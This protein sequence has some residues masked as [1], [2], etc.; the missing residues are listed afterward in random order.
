MND[1]AFVVAAKTALGFALLAFCA[2]VAHA[3]AYPAKPVRLIVPFSP[4]GG[5]DL[6]G[7][8][9]AQGLGPLLGQQV[10][11]E[12][13]PGAGGRIGTELLARAA[14]DGYTLLL[15]GSSAL[16][17][18]P[19]LYAKLPYRVPQDFAP[20][21]L[22]GRATYVLVVHPSV[23]AR[24]VKQ[25]VT[26]AKAQP[27]QLTYASSGTGSLGHLSGEFFSS[28]VSVKLIHVPYKGSAP[29]V[30]SVMTGETA[31]MFSNVVPA[32]PHLMNHRLRPLGVTGL[33]R[34]PLLPEVP[35]VDESGLRGF[36]VQQLYGFL[37]PAGT[38]GEIV[39]RLNQEAAR[40]M[41]APD[42]K[43]RLAAD[44]SEVAVSSPEEF[45]KI[46]LG[47]VAKWR[48][49]IRQAGITPE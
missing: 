39:R 27:G 40:V 18:A 16:V 44:G 14:P 33:A 47:E 6:L 49:V 22:I 19:A 32:L 30:L 35:T 10:I 20:I 36:E 2:P 12:N 5:T 11:V 23:P 38:P 1:S 13:R 15:V 45:E 8:S 41:Q 31:I 21:T 9:L 25:L 42:M 24:T 29:G 46:I 7:R 3:Q 4:G 26:L 43:K 34:S 48:K 17:T 28:L 37:A